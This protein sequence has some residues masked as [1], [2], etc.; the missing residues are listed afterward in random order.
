M[1]QITVDQLIFCKSYQEALDVSKAFDDFEFAFSALGDRMIVPAKRFINKINTSEFHTHRV[2]VRYVF[3]YSG[4]FFYYGFLDGKTREKYPGLASALENAD[5]LERKKIIFECQEKED[6]FCREIYYY[7]SFKS[8]LN[9]ELKMILNKIYLACCI[10]FACVCPSGNFLINYEE[11]RRNY[12]TGYSASSINAF[13]ASEK[14]I[15]KSSLGFIP[16]KEV[17]NWMSELYYNRKDKRYIEP[18]SLTAFSYVINRSEYEGLFYS[19]IGLES[20]FSKNERR[21]KSQLKANVP[22]VL[23]FVTSGEIDVF[24]KQKADFIHGASIYPLYY[25][26]NDLIDMNTQLYQSAQKAAVILLA[27]LRLL[28]KNDATKIRIDDTGRIKY[29]KSKTRKETA[30]D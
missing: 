5:P 12:E 22:Q 3:E 25:K 2:T 23:P 24:Y 7:E 29:I 16:I 9:R 19:I 18:K 1:G 21:A 8:F 27:T 11:D 4:E 28:V 6:E 26:R 14:F 20:V 10:A 30:L 15:D 17:W 13:I